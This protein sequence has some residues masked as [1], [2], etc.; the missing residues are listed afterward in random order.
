MMVFSDLEW[1]EYPMD[2][3]G[4]MAVAHFPNNRG[5]SIVRMRFSYGHED[6]LF[7]MAVTRKVKLEDGTF[8]FTLDYKSGITEDVIGRIGDQ[9]ITRYLQQIEALP[10]ARVR[11][12]K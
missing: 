1:K 6:G 7:E 8:A 3:L 5:A 10:K 9:E 11:R 4:M 2:E 12:V